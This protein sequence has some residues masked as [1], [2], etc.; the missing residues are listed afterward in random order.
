M[1]GLELASLAVEL[2][3][4]E[5]KELVVALGTIGGR[6]GAVSLLWGRTMRLQR[7]LVL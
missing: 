3:E 6:R 5:V 7:L 1:S 2:G 4:E